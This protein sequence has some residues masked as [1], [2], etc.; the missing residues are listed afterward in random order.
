M[1]YTNL[2]CY[3]PPSLPDEDYSQRLDVIVS[4]A[5]NLR[6]VVIAEDFNTWA[7]EWGTAYSNTNGECLLDAFETLD[8]VLTNNESSFSRNGWS[9]KNVLTFVS[10]ALFT[11]SVWKVSATCTH[12]DHQAIIFG[13]RGRTITR[14]MGHGRHSARRRR[15]GQNTKISCP[16]TSNY[17]TDKRAELKKKLS[18]DMS[19]RKFNPCGRKQPRLG[20]QILLRKIIGTLFT[21]S[22]PYSIPLVTNE[23]LLS[24]CN[25]IG[26]SKR[27]S[28]EAITK[29]SI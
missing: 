13:I 21:Q 17:G 9:S 25:K 4:E 2:S 8:A 16:G 3:F 22:R 27:T 15:E 19:G 20:C 10:D 11:S 7:V 14:E 12:S 18:A 29:A 24:I 5:R 28:T 1:E 23:E 26:D 6:S